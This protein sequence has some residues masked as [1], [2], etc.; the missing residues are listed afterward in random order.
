MIV[1]SLLTKFR[2]A[3]I[4]EDILEDM[5]K[6]MIQQAIPKGLVK[7]GTIIVDA[8]HIEAA[9]EGKKRNT[10]SERLNQN[11]AQGNL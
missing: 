11:A 7:S 8:T 10:G 6:E 9:V 4:T 2:K 5:Q 3:R 1:P